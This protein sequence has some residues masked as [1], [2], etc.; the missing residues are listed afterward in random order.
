VNHNVPHYS[1]NHESKIKQI[2]TINGQN[3]TFYVGAYLGNGLHEGAV[4]S[5]LRVASKL[6]GMTL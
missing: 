6:G 1:I 2:E 5:A 4:E 3:R